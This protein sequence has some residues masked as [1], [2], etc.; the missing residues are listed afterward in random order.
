MTGGVE[1]SLTNETGGWLVG[2]ADSVGRVT[3]DRSDAASHGPPASE[4][5]PSPMRAK[6]ADGGS[7]GPTA[8]GVRLQ[9]KTYQSLEK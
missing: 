9:H 8:K 1:I 6:I 4:Y 7:S 5:A 2:L 3:L